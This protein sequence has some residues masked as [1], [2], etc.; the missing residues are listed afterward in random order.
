MSYFRPIAPIT[1]D[2][3]VEPRIHRRLVEVEGDENFDKAETYLRTRA[4]NERP[5]TILRDIGD[6]RDYSQCQRGASIDNCSL[7][8]L[9]A[10]V[11]GM[12]HRGKRPLILLVTL[13]GSPCE[14]TR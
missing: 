11:D 6:L 1:D 14:Q 13:S 3:E 8:E 9:Q 2:E 10:F 5:N 7:A 4:V 12:V